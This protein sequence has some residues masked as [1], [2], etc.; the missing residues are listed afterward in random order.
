MDVA[1]HNCGQNHGA[2]TKTVEEH[3]EQVKNLWDEVG[4]L[5]GRPS[6]MVLCIITGLSSALTLACNELSNSK[7]W[8]SGIAVS[9]SQIQMQLSAVEKQQSVVSVAVAD[10]AAKA[11]AQAAVAAIKSTPK[12]P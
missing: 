2:L 1:D 10:T 6:W 4:K 5:R 7:K 12:V 3:G 9:L 8:E 11:A